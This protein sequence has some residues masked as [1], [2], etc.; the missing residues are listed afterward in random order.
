MTSVDLCVMWLQLSGS[1]FSI[2]LKPVWNQNSRRAR[3]HAI[4]TPA[5]WRGDVGSLPLD[6]ASTAVNPTYW[7]ISTQLKTTGTALRAM[8]FS[9][10]LHLDVGP[11]GTLDIRV[12]PAQNLTSESGRVDE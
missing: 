5:R 12:P 1:S 8:L 3:L 9:P 6:G 10:F 2:T 7:L 4:A 11:L